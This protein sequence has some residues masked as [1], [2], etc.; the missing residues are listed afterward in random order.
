MDPKQSGI[1]GRAYERSSSSAPNRVSVFSNEVCYSLSL[2]Y[3]IKQSKI[4]P[5]R[6]EVL[7]QITIDTTMFIHALDERICTILLYF[8]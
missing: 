7:R 4:R 3:D 8:Y 6:P 2:I 5:L 1:L